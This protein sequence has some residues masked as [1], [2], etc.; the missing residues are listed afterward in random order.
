MNENHFRGRNQRRE[1]IE[2]QTGLAF[3]T[4][5]YFCS[6]L[7]YILLDVVNVIRGDRRCADMQNACT[8]KVTNH[9]VKADWERH[10]TARSM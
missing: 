6:S 10:M 7:A 9:G 4:S 5:I 3:M 8:R 2:S 1:I